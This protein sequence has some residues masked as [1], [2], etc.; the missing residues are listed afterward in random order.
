MISAQHSVGQWGCLF[1]GQWGEGLFS[2]S[3]GEISVP[4]GEISV[5]A[6]EMSLPGTGDFV[7]YVMKEHG[8]REP[9]G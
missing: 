3:A 8:G 6:G 5:P 7:S 9:P 4:V 1:F 2:V